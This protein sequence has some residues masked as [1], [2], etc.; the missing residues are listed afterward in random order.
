MAMFGISTFA[1]VFLIGLL[2]YDASILIHKANEDSRKKA[3]LAGTIVLFVVILL[4]FRWIPYTSVKNFIV[5]V[6]VPFYTLQA[7][8]LL[9]EVRRGSLLPLSLSEHLLYLSFFPYFT[10][11]PIERSGAMVQQIRENHKLDVGKL[12]EVLLIWAR[13]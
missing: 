8:S 3:Y 6:G 11:G 7:I 5:P 10:S 2:L 13:E 12:R 9:I 4:G 1:T